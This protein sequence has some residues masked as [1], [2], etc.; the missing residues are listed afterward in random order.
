MMSASELRRREVVDA[1]TAERLGFVYDIE[2]DFETGV[3]QSII[4]PKKQNFFWF[5][6]KRREYII[7]WKNIA[8][9]GR[10]I[11]L[12]NIDSSF[13]FPPEKYKGEF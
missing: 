5:L 1:A 4:V 9:V 8:A 2:I 7:P 13:I 6:Q 11:I 12:V 10:D 3:I